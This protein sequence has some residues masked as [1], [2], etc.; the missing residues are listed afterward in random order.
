MLTCSRPKGA[1][2]TARGPDVDDLMFMR[3]PEGG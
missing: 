3:V 1:V 2:G